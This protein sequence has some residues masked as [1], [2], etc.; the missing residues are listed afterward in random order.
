MQKP[1]Q[2]RHAKNPL[3]VNRDVGFTAVFQQVQNRNA[4][5]TLPLGRVQEIVKNL[6]GRAKS[7][8]M[9]GG[10]WQ[11]VL[12]KHRTLTADTIANLPEFV[13]DPVIV[14]GTPE[15]GRTGDMAFLTDATTSANEVVAVAIRKRGSDQAGY[16]ASVVVTVYEASNLRGMIARAQNT[17]NVLYVR[18][19][20]AG[21]GY[22]HTGIVGLNAP[23]RGTFS[24]LRADSKIRT[25]RTVF[26]SGS[27][28]VVSKSRAQPLRTIATPQAQA[29]ASTA[30]IPVEISL[31]WS[32]IISPTF[33]VLTGP[34]LRP[35]Q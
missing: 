29:H 34:I 7:P 27:P 35:G 4:S 8:V 30:V 26:N 14:I 24:D 32:E 10:N 2:V 15:D 23:L 17:G 5:D 21:R 31:I 28:P 33:G 1:E 20:R 11:K 13:A 18:G 6:S 19:V 16:P 12:K 3:R 22:E 9:S 25:P